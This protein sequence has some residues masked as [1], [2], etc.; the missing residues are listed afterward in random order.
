MKRSKSI[1]QA[2]DRDIEKACK[3]MDRG[4]RDAL[5]EFGDRITQCD[6]DERALVLQAR[7]VLFDDSW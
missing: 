3:W 4:H 1:T 7:A 2:S 6:D 5:Q